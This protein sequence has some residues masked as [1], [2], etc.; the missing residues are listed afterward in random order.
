MNIK[1]MMTALAAGILVACQP[2]SGSG[3]EAHVMAANTFE[4]AHI[5]SKLQAATNPWTIDRTESTITFEGRQQ[6]ETFTG[7]FDRFDLAIDFDRHG[8]GPKP[9]PQMGTPARGVV[10]RARFMGSQSL[11]EFQMDFDG[12][13]LKALV[14][15]VFLPKPGTPFWIMIRR[16]R[17]HVFPAA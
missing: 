7:C 3:T 6:G 1:L 2:A 4:N 14:P 15:S 12:S 13:V 17:C 11:V 5:Q 9:T 16:D 8:S 10:Q